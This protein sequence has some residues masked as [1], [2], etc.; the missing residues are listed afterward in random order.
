MFRHET[1][2]SVRAVR[3]R[4]YVFAVFGARQE[5]LDVQRS[6]AVADESKWRTCGKRQVT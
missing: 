2:L 1:R 4:V 5:M 6:G 3:S